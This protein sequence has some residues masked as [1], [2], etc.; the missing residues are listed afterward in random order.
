MLA[1][2][3][4]PRDRRTGTVTVTRATPAGGSVTANDPAV[5]AAPL[6]AA[7]SD[8]VAGT[9]G[10][11]PSGATVL[12]VNAH[13]CYLDVRGTLVAVTTA[14]ASR[15][16]CALR[17]APGAPEPALWAG[18]G[19]PARVGRGLVVLPGR[20][21]RVARWWSPIPAVPPV[22]AERVA[23]WVADVERVARAAGAD[24]APPDGLLEALGGDDP[25]LAVNVADGLIGRGLGSTPAGDDVVAGALVTLRLLPTAGARRA[26][27]AVG[28]ALADHVRAVAPARTTWLSAALLRHAASGEP[29]GELADVLT[30]IAGQRPVTVPVRRLLAV[31]HTSG[32]D[33][34][35]GLLVAARAAAATRA[36]TEVPA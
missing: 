2:R 1:E 6:P 12:A 8:A 3:R 10:G 34:L 7:A 15:M 23:G 17:L 29:L 14:A 36:G 25:A 33:L 24:L 13:A 5:R 9:V 28:A 18:A 16:P 21:V 26:W 32:A 19:E 27:Q 11:E 31:G 20:A 4:A 35:T 22:P 30:S